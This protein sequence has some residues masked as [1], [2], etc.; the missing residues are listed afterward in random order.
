VLIPQPRTARRDAPWPAPGW[1]ALESWPAETWSQ[2][3]SA[4]SLSRKIQY[5]QAVHPTITKIH[6]QAKHW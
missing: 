5:T 4:R 6:D 1:R 3:A 2:L